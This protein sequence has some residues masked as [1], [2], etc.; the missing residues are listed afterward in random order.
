MNLKHFVFSSKETSLISYMKEVLRYKGLVVSLLLR[1]IKVKY[2]QTFLGFLW[3]V[4]QPL[5]GVFIF[6]FFFKYVLNVSHWNLA[7]PYHIYA[8]CGLNAWLLFSTSMQSAGTSLLNEE[9]LIKKVYFPR[10]ILPIVRTLGS[11]VDFM[12][13]TIVM[14][15]FAVISGVHLSFNIL[16]FP[17]V[18]MMTVLIS[19]SISV[20][21][22]A[23]TIRYR[24]FHHIIP[25]VINFGIWLTPVFYPTSILPEKLINILYLNPMVAVVELFRWSFFDTTFPQDAWKGLVIPV[26]LLLSGL[27]YFRKVEKLISDY[28]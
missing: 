28:L 6:T 8:F 14:L 1:D 26:I 19:L 15:I 7:I 23:L 12:M 24:D 18:L 9:Q 25:Y 4:I 21:L 10:L 16:F 11:V 3:V 22:S 27:I 17:V 20:W 2:A 5:T 13:A